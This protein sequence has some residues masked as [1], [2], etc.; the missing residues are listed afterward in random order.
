MTA[1]PRLPFRATNPAK[2][3]ICTQAVS[4]YSNVRIKR[5]MTGSHQVSGLTPHCRTPAKLCCRP[6]NHHFEEAR[7][8][9]FEADILVRIVRRNLHQV[10]SSVWVNLNG[11]IPASR[12]IQ[13]LPDRTH[14]RFDSLRRIK[15][16]KYRQQR[17]GGSAQGWRRIVEIREPHVSPKRMIGF[18][19]SKD[20]YARVA[21]PFFVFGY[22]SSFGVLFPLIV[23]RR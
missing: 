19:R 11:V 17:S 2:S 15:L 3:N 14:I 13:D 9:A 21:K 23:R 5:S 8:E 22:G 18:L 12:L 1:K 16:A 10:V 20:I 6:V 4:G 7:W